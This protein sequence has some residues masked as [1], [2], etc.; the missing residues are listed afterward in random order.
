LATYRFLLDAFL[1]SASPAE[2]QE[3]RRK[4]AAKSANPEATAGA[5]SSFADWQRQNFQ[6]LAFRARWQGYFEQIDVFLSP[7]A[8]SVAFPHD[9]SEPQEKRSIATSGG[10]RHYMD[11]LNWIGA[12]TLTGCP[13]TVAP[14][15]RTEGGL[16]VGIQIMGPY[17]EDATPITFADLLTREL[18]GFVAPLG[19]SG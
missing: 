15:G 10:P 2:Q 19:Y 9:H 7:V 16:P 6:R 5:L 8:F 1:F 3:A 13:A 12:A 17:W 4:E 11:L 18:G 14:V